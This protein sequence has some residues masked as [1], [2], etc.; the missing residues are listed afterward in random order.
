MINKMRDS[1]TYGKEL[2]SHWPIRTLKIATY[3]EMQGTHLE[4]CHER[5]YCV[6]EFTRGGMR[7][8]LGVKPLLEC[9]KQLVELFRPNDGPSCY[10]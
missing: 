1:E 6:K 8:F 2:P 3:T 10:T 7:I 9:R 5:L 4:F